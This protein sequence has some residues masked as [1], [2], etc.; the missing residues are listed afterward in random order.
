MKKLQIFEPAGFP[1]QT[2]SVSLNGTDE[3]MEGPSAN[4]TVGFSTT[5]SI[6]AWV[7]PAALTSRMGIISL[8]NDFVTE[9]ASR[10]S[11]VIR[12]DAAN[13][14][15]LFL[16]FDSEGTESQIKNLQYDSLFSVDTW[17]MVVVTMDTSTQTG[18]SY[19]NDGGALTP[20]AETGTSTNQPD[21][22]NRVVIIGAENANGGNPFNGNIHSVAIWDSVLTS[23]EITAIYN[24]GNGDSFDL[25]ADSGN[26]SSSSDLAHWWRIGHNAGDI[27]KDDATVPGG[28]GAIDITDS[29]NNITEGADI[30]T[31]SPGA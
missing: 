28:S 15:F 24:S 8:D 3:W 2:V 27:G 12:G 16:A 9:N 22:L 17:A 21:G 4:T 26:Y 6:M 7:K 18:I 10:V 25:N 5:F 29:A 11:V 20:D 30:V 31:D 1:A 23:D 14:P 19:L 13:D